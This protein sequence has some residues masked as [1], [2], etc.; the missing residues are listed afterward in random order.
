MQATDR[1]LTMHN[2][3]WTAGVHHDGSALY[4]SNPLPALGETVTLRLRV[5]LDA[6]VRRVYI[7]TMPDGER[8]L[9]AMARTNHDSTSVYWSGPL[10]AHMPYNPY[11]FKLITDEGAYYLNALGINRAEMPDSYDF[12][13]LADFEAVPWLEDAVFYQIF[14]DRFHNGDPSLNV[15]PDAWTYK[16]H[17]VQIREWGEP[18]LRYQESGSIDFYGGDLPGIQKKL[19]YIQQLGANALYLNPIFVSRSNHRYNIDDFFNVDPHL[20]G[21]E[22]LV[23]LREALD[24]AGMRVILDVTPN[25]TSNLHPWFTEAQADPNADSAEFY[26]FYDDERQDYLSWLGVHTL[27]KL[28]YASQKLRDAMYAQPDSVLQHWLRPPYRIDGWRLDVLNMTARHGADQLLHE[29]NAQMRAALKAEHPESYIF[30]E[31]FFDGTPYLQGDELDATMNYKGFNL[32]MWRWLSGHDLGTEWRPESTDPSPMPSDTFADQLD[33]F[34]AA[35]PWVIARQQFNQLCSHDTTRILTIVN[36]DKA[37]VKLGAAMLMTYPGVP[38]VYYGDEI[39]MDGENDPY[40]R[41]TMPWDEAEWDHDMLGHYRRLIELRRT[42]PAL[43]RGGYQRLFAKGDLWAFQRQSAEQQIV[44]VGYRGPRTQPP[45]SLPV[46]HAGL[47][48]GTR[49]VDLLGGES[50]VVENGALELPAL[51][52]GAALLLEVQR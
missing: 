43:R 51:E 45:S 11:Q 25:H 3:H 4:V 42:A 2:L 27:P 34:R 30:G 8:H 1:H 28:N 36:G 44:V 14:P 15:A 37:L 50:F 32:P 24:E 6:P 5:P 13:L 49:V 33:Y 21:N 9:D 47:A 29:V 40:N 7:C 48:D 18:P 12:K 10:K 38:C 23:A 16:G 39:G 17:S 20:G 46:W 22:A 41:R 19:D 26:I 31:H 35:I 52:R